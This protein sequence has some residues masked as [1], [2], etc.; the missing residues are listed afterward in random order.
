MFNSP[1]K[2]VLQRGQVFGEDRVQVVGTERKERQVLIRGCR[3]GMRTVLMARQPELESDTDLA[4]LVGGKQIGSVAADFVPALQR[5]L[6]RDDCDIVA[7]IGSIDPATA[8]ADRPRSVSLEVVVTAD[9]SVSR[10]SIVNAIGFVVAGGIRKAAKLVKA[11]WQ[12]SASRRYRS[13]R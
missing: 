6:K 4:V 9:L 8:T 1:Y 5:F 10:F 2:T 7:R 13:D 12:N 3:A 11:A